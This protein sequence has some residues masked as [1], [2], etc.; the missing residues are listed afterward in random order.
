[1]NNN[2][3]NLPTS[4]LIPNTSPLARTKL[5]LATMAINKP[6]TIAPMTPIR[7][8]KLPNKSAITAIISVDTK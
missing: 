3:N 1:M 6:L 5:R 4:L 8:T 7:P 2:E